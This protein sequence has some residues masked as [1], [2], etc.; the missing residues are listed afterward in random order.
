MNGRKVLPID[1]WTGKQMLHFNI[2]KV[3]MTFRTLGKYFS[4]QKSIFD[5]N[6]LKNT[7]MK[8]LRTCL[9]SSVARELA[10]P[11][12]AKYSYY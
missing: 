5:L 2:Q 10:K 8:L 12:T 7:Y 4:Y 1:F 11:T 9:A 3:M 6:D